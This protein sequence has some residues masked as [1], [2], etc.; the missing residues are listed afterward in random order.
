MKY[1]V[2]AAAFALA[3]SGVQAAGDA[4]AGK[5]LS[6]PCSAC[7]GAD[8]NSAVPSFPKLAGQHEKYLLKQLR[9]VKSGAR[10]IPTMIGQLDNLSDQD[11]QN[12]AAYFSSQ[13][14]S[15]AAAKEE[16]VALGEKV[17]RGGVAEKGVAAC[18]ACHGA[19]GVGNGPAG[20]PRLGGQYADYIASSLK[21]YRSGE[22]MNDGDIRIMRDVAS[23]LSDKEI[24]AV[25]SYASGLY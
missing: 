2:L 6:V 1:L 12:L 10:M 21:A 25:A 11:L 9:D 16:L 15:P 24:E 14:G 18:I 8:G 4:S 5:A 7:H 3:A 19:T 20:F 23:R 22:R 13:T 17:Y